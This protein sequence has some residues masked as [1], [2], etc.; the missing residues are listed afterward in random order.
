MGAPALPGM[1]RGCKFSDAPPC[2]RACD[3]PP[4]L[5]FYR[6]LLINLNILPLSM[7]SNKTLSYAI[8]LNCCISQIFNEI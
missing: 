6:Y 4:E 1:A 7:G 2:V 8:R 5:R 3:E